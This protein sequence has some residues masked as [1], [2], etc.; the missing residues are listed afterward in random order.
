MQTVPL[1]SHG[2]FHPI[3]SSGQEHRAHFFS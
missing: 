1:S 2:L 3:I